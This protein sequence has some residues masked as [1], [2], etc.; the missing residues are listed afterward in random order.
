MKE[1]GE[2]TLTNFNAN[3]EKRIGERKNQRPH[4][5]DPRDGKRGKNPQREIQ[6]AKRNAGRHLKKDEKTV[7]FDTNSSWGNEKTER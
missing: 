5:Q 6:A 4:E 7:G 2:K 3:G 1:Q